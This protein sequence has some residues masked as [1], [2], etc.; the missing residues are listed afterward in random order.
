MKALILIF[1]LFSVSSRCLAS[2]PARIAFERFSY[3][4]AKTGERDQRV[5]AYSNYGE[6]LF[7]MDAHPASW[8]E[9]F[10]SIEAGTEALNGCA[11]INAIVARI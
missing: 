8:E 6:D 11:P 5:Q 4:L 2:T 7:R 3:E 9:C 1:C 10:S